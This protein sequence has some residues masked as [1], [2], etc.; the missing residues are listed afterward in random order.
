MNNPSAALSGETD[1]KPGKD[2]KRLVGALAFTAVGLVVIVGGYTFLDG[3]LEQIAGFVGMLDLLI[4]AFVLA[5]PQGTA[6]TISLFGIV[7]AFIVMLVGAVMLGITGTTTPH[8][9]RGLGW[10]A[11]ITLLPLAFY[12]F[13][14][15]LIDGPPASETVAADWP[16]PGTEAS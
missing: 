12:T 6:R 2:R 14:T 5:A 9:G 16:A 15:K 11:A 4:V 3:P 13:K 10:T 1:G 7:C 8:I